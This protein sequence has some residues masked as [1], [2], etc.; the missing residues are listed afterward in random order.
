MPSQTAAILLGKG[1]GTFTRPASPATGNQPNGL[2]IGDFNGDGKANLAITG[3]CGAPGIQM[4]I[5]DGLGDGDFSSVTPAPSR[6][7]LPAEA[8]PEI[9]A[10]D[11]NGDGIPDVIGQQQ[12][13]VLVF[14]T[15]RA[16]IA[17]LAG[18]VLSTG[19]LAA[20]AWKPRGHHAKRMRSREIP[21]TLIG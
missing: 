11:L 16:Q 17:T 2:A 12:D 10:C 3:F 18:L 7:S 13:R 1:D 14:L 20:A 8:I 9:A 15:N 5:L 19:K 4:F 21:G 6:Y